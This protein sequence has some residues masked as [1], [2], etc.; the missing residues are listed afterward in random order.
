VLRVMVA[1]CIT[2]RRLCVQTGVDEH[3][4]LEHECERIKRG[5]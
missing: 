4:L 2:V 5:G 3:H 1:M